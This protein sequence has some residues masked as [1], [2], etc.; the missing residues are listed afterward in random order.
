MA[1]QQCA[2]E[3]RDLGG[4]SWGGRNMAWR[5]Y[6]DMCMRRFGISDTALERLW[7]EEPAWPGE[8]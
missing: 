1:K 5:A 8:F 4:P 7:L 2:Q 3:A 6:F